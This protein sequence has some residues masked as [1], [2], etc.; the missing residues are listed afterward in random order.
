MPTSVV[1]SYNR[2][3]DHFNFQLSVLFWEEDG[4]HYAY[5]PALDLTGHG[6]SKQEAKRSFETTLDAFAKYTHN[7]GTIYKELERLGWTI[8]KKKR[9]VK[10]PDYEEMLEDN[11]TLRE[12]SKRANVVQ[13]SRE[14]ALAL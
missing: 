7:K 10:A 1:A 8:N 3:N 4:I 14:V 9:R 2:D 11:E 13:E 5:S 12:L 6:K